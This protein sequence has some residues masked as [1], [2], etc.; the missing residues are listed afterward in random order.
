MLGET[1]DWLKLDESD[2]GVGGCE[3]QSTG[4][5]EGLNGAAGK[6]VGRNKRRQRDC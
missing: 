3:P 2:E 4:L 5:A 1:A 6:P